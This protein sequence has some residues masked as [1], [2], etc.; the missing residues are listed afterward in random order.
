MSNVYDDIESRS[1]G[2]YMTNAFDM[3]G[4]TETETKASGMFLAIARLNH[5][6]TPN[7][8]QTYIPPSSSGKLNT[9]G[10]AAPEFQQGLRLQVVSGES[11]SR[12]GLIQ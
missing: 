8:Q 3:P 2:I 7:A 12:H 1:A 6:C 11:Y 9:N 4:E 10:D 5:S